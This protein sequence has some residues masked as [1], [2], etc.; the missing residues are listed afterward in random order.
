MISGDAKGK[1]SWT[2]FSRALNAKLRD[3]TARNSDAPEG[4]GAG[5][6]HDCFGRCVQ[7]RWK[8]RE[9]SSGGELGGG[10]W[11]SDLGWWPW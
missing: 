1:V 4:F 9:T 6:W 11:G 8:T 3:G 2:R 10:S 7:K 5:E